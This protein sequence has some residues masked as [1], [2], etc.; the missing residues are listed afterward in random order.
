MKSRLFLCAAALVTL[1]ASVRGGP[2]TPVL[3]I[4]DEPPPMSVKQAGPK[5][6]SKSSSE[7]IFSPGGSYFCPEGP[8]CCPCETCCP[9]DVCGPP[10]R[11]WVRAEYLLWAVKGQPL[12]PL[13][14]TSPPGTPRENAGV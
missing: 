10:G 4:Y 3:V 12:P 7:V 6:G 9:D 8:S 13:L 1:T 14:T 11:A 2:P 5:A